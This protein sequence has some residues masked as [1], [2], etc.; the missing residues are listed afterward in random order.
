MSKSSKFRITDL[1]SEHNTNHFYARTN[2]DHMG[3]QYNMSSRL[4]P[5]LGDRRIQYIDKKVS[6][7]KA[8]TFLNNIIMMNMSQNM[9]DLNR[10]QE[11]FPVR[12]E[13]LKTEYRRNF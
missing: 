9:I 4:P 6:Y 8:A 3:N 12:E 13:E 5:I 11:L 1:I 7:E 10:N 2:S